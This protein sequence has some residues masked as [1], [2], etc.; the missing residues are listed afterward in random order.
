MAHVDETR[1]LAVPPADTCSPKLVVRLFLGQKC[2]NHG[3]RAEKNGSLVNTRSR[4]TDG[5]Q[6]SI[7][8]RVTYER[9]TFKSL[10]QAE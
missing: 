6:I 8:L 9:A 10:F 4:I 1:L 7:S 3:V 2:Q 5:F